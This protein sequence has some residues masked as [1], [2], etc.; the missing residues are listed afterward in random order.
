MKKMDIRIET[1]T[2]HDAEIV[3]DWIVRLL[4]ELGEEGDEL[5]EL[6]RDKVLRAWKDRQNKYHVLVARNEAGE[7]LGILTLSVAFAIYANGEYGVIDEMFVAPPFRSA[8]V[9]A[10]LVDVARDMERNKDGRASMSLHRNPSVGNEHG[11]FMKS[12]ASCSLAQ[13]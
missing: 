2:I 4:R 10:Q 8:G 1:L 13:S 11:S 7:I 12:S 5:G 9:G 3:F 6:A